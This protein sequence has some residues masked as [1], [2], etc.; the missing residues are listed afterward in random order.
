MF[1]KSHLANPLACKT[2]TILYDWIW[3]KFTMVSYGYNL[4][5]KSEKD[6]HIRFTIG[7][8]KLPKVYFSQT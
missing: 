7:T 6:L 8:V 5:V 2:K 1:D 4:E 3:I